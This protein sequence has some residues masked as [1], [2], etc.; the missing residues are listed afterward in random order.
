MDDAL[1]IGWVE[2]ARLTLGKPLGG[3]DHVGIKAKVDTGAK[4]S[5]IHAVDIQPFV[6]DGMDY[7]GFT[8]PCNGN[9]RHVEAPLLRRGIVKSSEGQ[10]V[11]RYFVMAHINIGP[12]EAPIVLS[13][14]DRSTMIYPVLLGRS[15]LRQKFLVDVSRK[16][17]LGRR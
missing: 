11:E 12:V 9:T 15:F 2:K 8:F 7:L 13:L 10:K 6:R 1:T 4:T 14:N 3:L 17:I 16:F 5:S